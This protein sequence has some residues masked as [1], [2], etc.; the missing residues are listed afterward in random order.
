[1]DN[2]LKKKIFQI[3]QIFATT[4]RYCYFS[5]ISKDIIYQHRHI[6]VCCCLI[7]RKV[8][9]PVVSGQSSGNVCPV[10]FSYLHWQDAKQNPF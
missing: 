3:N 5:I 7:L 4:L 2:G 1:M 8:K 10:A 6:V 9:S